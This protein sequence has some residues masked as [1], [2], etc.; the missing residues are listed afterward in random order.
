MGTKGRKEGRRTMRSRAGAAVGVVP[1]LMDVH[2]TFGGR[3]VPGD[4]VGDGGGGGFGA[5][6]EGDET[7][8][9]GI[10]AENGDCLEE[11]GEGGVSERG[12]RWF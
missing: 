11:P 6:L 4:V 3:V 9:G 10:P 8:D 5:L 7:T 1:E 12:R 2:A